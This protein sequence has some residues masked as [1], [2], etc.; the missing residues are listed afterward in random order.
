M[1]LLLCSLLILTSSCSML[2]GEPKEVR[3]L[4]QAFE[5]KNL[6]MIL[7]DAAAYGHFG[8]AGY[9]RA[10]TPVIDALAA[11]SL[12][13]ETAYSPAASTGHSVYAMLTSSYPFLAE[14]QGLQGIVDQPF[15]VTA[16]TPLMAEL[17]AP[18][19]DHRTGIS[20]NPWFGPDFGSDRGFTHFYEAYDSKA[21]PDSNRRYGERT[22]DLFRQDLELWGDTP[23][24]SYVH[25]LEP[26]TPYT[27]PESFAR[28]FH[29]T[30]VD[31]VDAEARALLLYRLDPPTLERQEMIRALYDANLAYVDS[32]V[33]EIF[34][35][36][37]DAGR[38]ED[39]V[40]LVIAD[41]GEAFWQHGVWA[42]GRHI[43]EEFTRIPLIMH[44]PGAPGL[45][46]KRVEE[47]V[48]LIDLLPSYLDLCGQEIPEDLEGDSLIPLIG[49][50]TESFAWRKVF[51]RNT[52]SIVPE[53]GVRV[54]RYKWI[55][56]VYEGSYQ[57][58][59]LLE[60]PNETHDLVAAG[61]V[62][63]EAAPFKEQIA[64]WIAIGTERVEAVTD[65]DPATRERLRSIGYF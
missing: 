36:L 51:L 40:V 49:G 10:T 19:F 52:H 17:L 57:L 35:S 55:Y 20:A 15:R 32:L 41:H 2:G 63:D 8:Y 22:L 28:R 1:P 23:S 54:G 46:G 9:D 11:Q 62:P 3:E 38:W 47:P 58:Y 31:S 65:M 59:D 60:D 45:V 4:R 25:F 29:A 7:L 64:L 50:D 27:P 43:F 13:F 42:H 61:A 16:D 12:V 33:G 44:I 26:H 6:V 48:S 30:A 18:V 14:K 5:G 37:K 24:F 56:R 21:V 39:T 34:E 53:Y